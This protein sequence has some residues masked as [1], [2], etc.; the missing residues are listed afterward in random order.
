VVLGTVVLRYYFTSLPLPRCTVNW[1]G[2]NQTSA[3]TRT[4]I[5]D[6]DLISKLVEDPIAAS[7]RDEKEED[8]LQGQVVASIRLESPRGLAKEYWVFQNWDR[9]K[10]M[11]EA[12]HYRVK[13]MLPGA[14]RIVDLTKLR[15]YLNALPHEAGAP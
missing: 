2:P 10:R 5:V 6:P 1:C 12:E 15:D 11:T 9:V 3:R 8:W 14:G 13:P 7:K 4:I